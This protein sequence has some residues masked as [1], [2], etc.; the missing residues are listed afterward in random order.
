[1]KDK[2]RNIRPSPALR[3]KITIILICALVAALV[4]V[5]L[6]SFYQ[7]MKSEGAYRHEYAGRVI[8]KWVTYQETES[9]TRVSG[10]LLIRSKNGDVF[11]VI[12]SPE[13]YEQAKVECWVIKDKNGIQFFATEP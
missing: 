5:L 13:S 2:R 8:D 10:H 3:Q 4:I 9:G 12:V 6:V 11:Q 1:V 7:R